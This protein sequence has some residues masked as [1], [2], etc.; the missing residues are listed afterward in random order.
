M[1]EEMIGL[2]LDL[3]TKMTVQPYGDR[4][5]GVDADAVGLAIVGGGWQRDGA[6]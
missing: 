2:E 5:V 6:C 3:A 4:P 1:P